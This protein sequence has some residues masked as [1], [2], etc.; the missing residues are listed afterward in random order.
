MN[1]TTQKT[2]C[3]GKDQRGEQRYRTV[4]DTTTEITYN[5]GAVYGTEVE[6]DEDG[7]P[8]EYD[9]LLRPEM[10]VTTT[11]TTRENKFHVRRLVGPQGK[12]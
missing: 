4:V 1:T 11:V 9:V 7:W 8:H 10:T 3:A 2:L 5:L 6:Y 12:K